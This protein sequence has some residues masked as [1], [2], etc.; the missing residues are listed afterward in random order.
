MK[1]VNIGNDSITSYNDLEF[2]QS[3]K[4]SK[5]GTMS[6][7]KNR[8]FLVK[9]QATADYSTWTNNDGLKHLVLGYDEDLMRELN[10]IKLV[11]ETKSTTPI[12]WKAC[13]EEKSRLFIKLDKGCTS[14]PLNC[15]LK[16]TIA[17]YGMFVQ[18]SSNIAFLQ[19]SIM[20]NKA[21]KL[22]FL[23]QD[24]TNFTTAPI[25]YIPNSELW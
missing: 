22:S 3:Q 13:S 4:Q 15:E 25:N 23:K 10:A 6:Y 11:I 14:I 1:V 17:V 19:F 5:Y 20:E 18:K 16:Y 9:N 12:Q 7:F 24:E 2:S 21:E 8:I